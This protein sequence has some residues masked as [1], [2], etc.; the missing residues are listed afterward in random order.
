MRII[1]VVI[2]FL[3]LSSCNEKKTSEK[4][5]DKKRREEIELLVKNNSNEKIEN[6][7]IEIKEN[8]KKIQIDK[9]KPTEKV[10]KRYVMPDKKSDVSYVISF[11]KNEKPKM[12]VTKFYSDGKLNGHYF[13]LIIKNE[14]VS[15]DTYKSIDNKNNNQ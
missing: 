15:I 10:I 7:Q 5:A 11:L 1:L 6:I 13:D 14:N 9:I 8:E 4:N 2:L 3:I 12:Y